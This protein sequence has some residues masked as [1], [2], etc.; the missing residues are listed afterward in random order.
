VNFAYNSAAITPA[1][2]VTAT[3]L[4]RVR[5]YQDKEF[6]GTAEHPS[7]GK[8]PKSDF[9]HYLKQRIVFDTAGMC[10]AITSVK[11]SLVE[12]PVSRIVFGTDYPQEIRSKEAVRDF[13]SNIRSLGPLGE[14]I[15]SG[16][17]GLLLDGSADRALFTT[18]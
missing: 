17:N 1:A 16:N 12:I 2:A 9:D 10:G 8:L 5:K 13:V 3:M 18:A 6:W 14:Q 4:G 15:L 11:A 7:H